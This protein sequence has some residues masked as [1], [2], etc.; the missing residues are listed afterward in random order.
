M[1]PRHAQLLRAA[2]F[3]A[4]LLLAQPL[5]GGLWRYA[6][7]VYAAMLVLLG[8]S[9]RGTYEIWRSRP[10]ARRT[11]AL[12]AIGFVVL[13]FVPVWF[14]HAAETPT[15]VEHHGHSLWR[16]LHVH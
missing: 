9:L 11:L 2:S 14:A 4:A 15:G 12:F 8:V 10:D 3:P 5:D 1:K 16:M 6:S 13:S 7:L